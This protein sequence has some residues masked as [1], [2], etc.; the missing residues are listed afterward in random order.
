MAKEG[1]LS[2]LEPFLD[3]IR[4]VFLI[5]SAM[6][7]FAGWAESAGI[8]YTKSHTLDIAVLEAHT[9]AQSE[10]GQPGGAGTVLLSPACAS[11]DQFRNYG[12]RGEVFASLV[13]ALSED[14]G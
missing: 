4:H 3:K 10:R 14:A 1:G 7:E 5:G 11:W 9:V 8:P 6:D 12:H 13:N 2:A